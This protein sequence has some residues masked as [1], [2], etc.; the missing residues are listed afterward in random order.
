MLG[1]KTGM[2]P[3]HTVWK[4]SS[5]AAT[6]SQS[7]IYDYPLW[8]QNQGLP[9]FTAVCRVEFSPSP[10]F[11]KKLRHLFVF[12]LSFHYFLFCSSLSPAPVLRFCSLSAVTAVQNVLE[13]FG[14]FTASHS[15]L[16]ELT[17]VSRGSLVESPPL[18]HA[19]WEN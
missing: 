17:Q 8:A 5:M 10:S 2:K 11:Q 14:P 16:C 19:T 4:V 13:T 3:A 9:L 7:F 6:T 15:M 1:L 12:L 18:S